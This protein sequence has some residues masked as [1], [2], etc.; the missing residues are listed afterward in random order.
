[1][2]TN[3]VF[4]IVDDNEDFMEL[5]ELWINEKKPNTLLKFTNGEELLEHLENELPS[6][7][8]AIFM[9][10]KLENESGFQ[11]SREVR[12]LY[13]EINVIHLT[14]LGGEPVIEDNM[15]VL[16][17]DLRD[18]QFTSEYILKVLD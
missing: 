17:K 15:V 4:I 10:V 3:R 14:G 7:V 18:N 2:F 8:G 16:D 5:F 1:M 13:P 9:D 11:I 12:N 6:R